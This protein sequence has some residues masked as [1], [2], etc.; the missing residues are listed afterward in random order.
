MLKIGIVGLPNVG[1]STLF[2]ALTKQKVDTSIYPF[3]TI[4]PNVGIVKVPEKRLDALAKAFPRPKVIPPVIEFV[5][6]AGLVKDAH[7]GQGLGNQFLAHIR[8]VNAILEIVRFFEREDVSHVEKGINPKRDIEILEGELIAKDLETIENRLKKLERKVKAQRKEAKKEYELL[9]R[10]KKE[11]EEGKKIIDLNLKEEE[12]KE[13]RDLFLL[14]A[15]PILYVYN[16]SGDKPKISEELKRKNYILL[17]VKLEE[18]LSEMAEEEIKDLEIEP[19]IYDLIKKA[20]E[21]LDLIIFFTMNKEEIRAWEVESG[22]RAPQAGG[23]I[24]SD[25]E[26]KF[27]KAEV[28]P[29]DKLIEAG[30][31]Q[32]AKEKGLINFVGKDYQVQDGDAI[33]FII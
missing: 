26:E 15:K 24:H 3:C 12:K 19:K 7:K 31:W 1:K 30:S 27:I 14:T 6:I 18:E 25:F 23:V 9:E 5:D 20:Y 29:W 17:D 11:L 22:T 8:E 4:N 32:K 2:K 16:F 33:Y 10:L 13:I 28:I 21:L